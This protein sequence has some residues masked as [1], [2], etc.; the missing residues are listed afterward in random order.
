MTR[1]LLLFAALTLGATPA[2]AQ[3]AGA[4]PGG[5]GRGSPLLESAELWAHV[6]HL[7]SDELA[8]RRAGTPGAERAARYIVRAFQETGLQ[9]PPDQTS[10]LQPFDFT[11]GVEPGSDNRLILQRGNRVV[12]TFA[13]GRDFLPLGG[14]LS[15][16]VVQSVV[17]VGYG[18]SAP[19]IGYDD[20]AG[21]DVR[22]KIVLALRWTPEGDDPAGRFGAYRFEHHKAATARDKG[23]RAILFVNPPATEAIDRLIPFSSDADPQTLGIVALSVS[24]GVATRIVA[25][26]GGDLVA[27]Q[28]AIDRSGRPA[29]RPL[30]EAVLN[31]RSD[32]R[33]RTR[34]THNVIGIV[35]GRD[36]NRTGEVVVIGAHYDGLGLGGR[37]SLDPVPGEIHNG[38]DDNAS[39]VAALLD[40]AQ[41]FAYPTNRPQRTLVFVAFGAEEE[42]LQGST[43]FVADPPVPLSS[44]VAMINLDMIGRLEDE[45]MV[46]GIGSSAAWPEMLEAAG[47]EIGLPLRLMAEGMGPSDHAAFYLRQIPVLA[48]F[49]GVH[50]DYHRS[51]DDAAAIDLEGLLQ[52]TRLVRN[53]VTRVANAPMRPAFDPTEYAHR[54]IVHVETAEGVRVRLGAVPAPAAAGQ[55]V[56]IDA[57][58]D[59][60]PA[61]RAGLQAGDRIVR[62]A[63]RPTPTIYEYVRALA[64]LEP[65]HA[66][67]VVVERRGARIQLDVTPAAASPETP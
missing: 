24:Q 66:V 61:A 65:D 29:S 56:V 4:L 18:I 59:E 19:T 62:I 33:A 1:I 47:A 31:L 26:G 57:V 44:V 2:L 27:W 11:V 43:R 23:A 17:F 55:G 42:R 3:L 48:F 32:L 35:P 28:R 9:P 39:G 46:Y 50:E 21:V 6:D 67:R 51:T 53:V 60:S 16:R 25:V 49:T 12:T 40:L 37:G 14:S 45:L 64:Q 58:V 63:G 10:H 5:P 41:F 54:E 13:P 34:T 8:G 20:Y 30:S 22:G 38:A 7:A 52:V 15:D 36:T